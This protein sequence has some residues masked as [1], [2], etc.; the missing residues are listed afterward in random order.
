MGESLLSE[1][2]Q[3]FMELFLKKNIDLLGLKCPLPVLKIQKA[4][5][6]LAK[7]D[8]LEVIANDPLAIIDVPA[9]CQESG[10]K[11]ILQERCESGHIFLI[12]CC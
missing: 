8:Q 12:E 6:G 9:F 7:G 4:L 10:H 3:W 5:K 1:L 11:L 2:V